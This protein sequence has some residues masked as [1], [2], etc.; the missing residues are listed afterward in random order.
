[1]DKVNKI[2][3]NSIKK[4]PIENNGKTNSSEVKVKHL[5]VVTSELEIE[6]A[7]KSTL[8]NSFLRQRIE[9]IQMTK[10][11]LGIENQAAMFG[12]GVGEAF[13]FGAI[14][15]GTGWVAKKILDFFTA[16]SPKSEVEDASKVAI[17]AL[18]EEGYW[19][20][21]LINMDYSDRAKA[22]D[23]IQNG[24]MKNPQ[25]TTNKIESSLRKILSAPKD[26]PSSDLLRARKQVV[27]GLFAAL[28]GFYQRSDVKVQVEKENPFYE[29]FI[30][31]LGEEHYLV[32]EEAKLHMRRVLVLN[33]K[34]PIR[35]FKVPNPDVRSGNYRFK[36]YETMLDTLIEP[37]DLGIETKASKNDPLYLTS[38][39]PT[40][41]RDKVTELRDALVLNYKL[42][43]KL[44][45][46]DKTKYDPS[47]RG[48]LQEVLTHATQIAPLLWSNEVKVQYEEDKLYSRIFSKFKEWGC[49][50]SQ[51]SEDELKECFKTLAA[52]YKG[53]EARYNAP[54][55]NTYENR[56]DDDLHQLRELFLKDECCS[57]EDLNQIF[58][59]IWELM[60]LDSDKSGGKL[61]L[62][63]YRKL[64][65]FYKCLNMLV[66]K[67]VTIGENSP[68]LFKDLLNEE[69][70]ERILRACGAVVHRYD[71]FAVRDYTFFISPSMRTLPGQ[72]L[73]L[74]HKLSRHFGDEGYVD[75]Y[76]LKDRVIKNVVDNLDNNSTQKV[77]GGWLCSGPKGTGKS[78]FAEALAN[79]M[80]LPLIVL[81]PEM[82]EHEKGN[83]LVVMPSGRKINLGEFFV[84]VK[85]NAPCVLLLDEVEGLIV[86]RAIDDNYI[87]KPTENEGKLTEAFLSTLQ[88]FRNTRGASNVV[89]IMTTNAPSTIDV[90]IELI[91]KEGNSTDAE[92][93]LYK[94]V[95]CNATRAKRIDHRIFS[96][97]KLY[98][99]SQ[100][101]ALAR[102]FLQPYIDSRKIQPPSDY[103]EIGSKI[104]D[105]P[106]A[107]IETSF[108]EVANKSSEEQVTVNDM[109]NHLK[110]RNVGRKELREKIKQ[111]VK[112]IEGYVSTLIEAMQEKSLDSSLDYTELALRSDGL[113]NTQIWSAIKDHT[114]KVLTQE[115]IIA[116]F[117]QVRKSAS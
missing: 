71:S 7:T 38:G 106:P 2:E 35:E 74:Y 31:Y 12:G 93:E 45:T 68:A 33:W 30:E 24:D 100:G 99:L 42:E 49:E 102:H 57:K 112:L 25:N 26:L 1:M 15:G 82:I 6:Q 69:N 51:M 117:E 81:S 70:K 79:Q 64:E 115:N 111:K 103:A 46:I 84:S 90:D 108:T 67:K 109:I 52:E 86:P 88:R 60:N 65:F 54:F 8:H 11:E 13:L 85:T 89:V 44:G 34:I 98:N 10:K 48:K 78:S 76:D 94:H 97:H 101:E 107:Q 92:Q 3:F 66:D 28:E 21:D 80:A 17:Q 29:K 114:P 43:S 19:N 14:A 9:A 95:S 61:T 110:A 27:R 77:N 104:S 105:Y 5:P 58:N 116:A 83:I 59:K 4:K 62:Q 63:N 55:T 36:M 23:K 73:T 53:N 18:N 32:D 96:F 75:I 56:L 50:L 113:T 22:I 72:A 91:D 87:R 20:D 41:L 37:S 40:V 39:A 47:A 16:E